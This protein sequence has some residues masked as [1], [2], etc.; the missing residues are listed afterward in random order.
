[1]NSTTTLE[2]AFSTR[3]NLPKADRV[4]VAELLN[5]RLADALDLQSQCK[6]AHW[7]VK[8]PNFIA[9]HKLFDECIRRC[10]RV[11]RPDRGAHRSAGWR[12]VRHRSRRGRGIGTR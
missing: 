8:G 5:R 4:Q 9:L 6:Q 12:G 3:N 10:Y 11:R 1:M 2:P 7:N